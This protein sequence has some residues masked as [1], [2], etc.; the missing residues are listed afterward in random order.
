MNAM[1]S[2]L[3]IFYDPAAVF[4]KV[5]ERG[6]WAAPLIA[7]AL[8]TMLFGYYVTRTIGMENI[9]RR[10]FEEHPSL[11][12]QIPPDKMEQAIRQSASPARVFMGSFFGGVTVAVITL[13]IA[14][15]LMVML[16][17]MDRKL[18]FPQVFGTVVWSTF[19]F[20]VITCIMGVLI[21][22]IS[23]DPSELNPQT[24]V[25]TSVGAFL[26]KNSTGQF[27]Y[28]VAGSIDVLAIGKVLLLSFGVSKVAGVSFGKALALLLILWFAWILLRAG[29][30]AATGF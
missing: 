17:I 6:N 8:L 27:L 24:L 3:Q 30:A 15:I 23:R 1:A 13:I 11:A 2:F 7:T 25:A 19:P 21:L 5:R 4:A 20:T 12:R 18:Q 22:F 14:A 10:V 29:V 9:T 26:D 28:S 16:S